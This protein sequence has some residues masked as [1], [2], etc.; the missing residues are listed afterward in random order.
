MDSFGPLLK[1]KGQHWSSPTLKLKSLNK[2][3]VNKETLFFFCFVFHE[4][5]S[6]TSKHREKK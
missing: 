6:Q 1:I 5:I 4:L 2:T 3:E